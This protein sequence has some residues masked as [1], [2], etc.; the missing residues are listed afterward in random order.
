MYSW[1][2]TMH[3]VKNDVTIVVQL[4]VCQF[5]FVEGNDLFHPV[6]A[7]S[8]RVRVDVDTGWSD[9][10]C[11]SGHNPGRAVGEETGQAERQYKPPPACARPPNC[12]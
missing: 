7:A 4:V 5:D 8:R 1:L 3:R 6:T 12:E 2:V 11:F 9:C 10:I